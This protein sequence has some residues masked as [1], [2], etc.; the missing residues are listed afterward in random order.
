MKFTTV[1][2][3]LVL[4]LALI[5]AS[6]AFA[7]TKASLDLQSTVNVNGTTLKPGEYK[8]QWEGTGPDVQVSFIQGRNVV[9]K[10]SARLVDLPSPAE[11]TAAVVHQNGDGT[12]SL[13]AAR[14]EGKKYSLQLD[15]PGSA[16]MGSAK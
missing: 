7:G 6:S 12:A 10:V 3:S 5:L 11:N 16:Q 1:T 9:A 13:A 14:F 4:G 15:T 2:K 8:L